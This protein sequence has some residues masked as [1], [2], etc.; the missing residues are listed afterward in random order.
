MR[1]LKIKRK[2]LIAVKY[3]FNL[4]LS[5]FFPYTFFIGPRDDNRAI[6]TGSVSIFMPTLKYPELFTRKK[7]APLSNAALLGPTYSSSRQLNMEK[8]AKHAEKAEPVSHPSAAVSIGKDGCRSQTRP[9]PSSR[10]RAQLRGNTSGGGMQTLFRDV[11]WMS[12]FAVE[13]R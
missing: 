12:G 11:P 13:W 2:S 7:P 3:G 5:F 4:W 1:S 9:S 8:N 6:R 10:L